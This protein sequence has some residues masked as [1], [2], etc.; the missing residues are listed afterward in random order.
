M[1]APAPRRLLWLL[2]PV[3]AF[4]A[5]L[6]LLTAVQGGGRAHTPGAVFDRPGLATVHV[7]LGASTAETIAATRRAIE[8]EP[9][10]A[11]L[12]ATLGDLYYQRGRERANTIWNER[13][14]DAYGRALA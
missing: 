1:T 10:D 6:A 4:A 14:H 2:A 5:T 12:R 8:D 3:A 11:A 13:A 7:P 9:G